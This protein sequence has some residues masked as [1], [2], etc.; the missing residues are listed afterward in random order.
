MSC[1]LRDRLLRI[2]RIDS[3]AADVRAL[4]SHAA[5]CP[6]CADVLAM[7]RALLPRLAA[8]PRPITAEERARLWAGIERESG[9]S[10]RE[11][12]DR[13]WFAAAAAAAALAALA[14]AVIPRSRPAPALTAGRAEILGASRA[15]ANGA[16]PEAEWLSFGARSRFAISDGAA[17]EVAEP[18]LVW[19]SPDEDDDAREIRLAEGALDAAVDAVDAG[20]ARTLV[21]TTPIARLEAVSARFHVE[22][23]RGHTSVE[24]SEGRV[25]IARARDEDPPV[26]RDWR[27]LAPGE[28]ATL[29]APAMP[30]LAAR[31]DG[32][33][34]EAPASS[35]PARA[36]PGA[37]QEHEPIARAPARSGGGDGPTAERPA[38]RARRGEP[39]HAS[40]APATPEI[41]PAGDRDR[42][43]VERARSMLGRDDRAATSLAEEVLERR[44]SH[45][46]EILALAVAAD[47]YRRRGMLGEADAY[48][49]RVIA[50][51]DGAGFREEALH[52]RAAIALE[53]GRATDALAFLAGAKAQ[54]PH[55]ALGP[56]RTALEAKALLA[57]GDRRAAASLLESAAKSAD[58]VLDRARLDVARALLA[59]DPGRARALIAPLMSRHNQFS[60]E[61][62]QIHRT[63]EAKLRARE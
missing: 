21:L 46:T 37:R 39:D 15:V 42:A 47:A 34:A 23:T 19:I 53:L 59:D 16:L 45:A 27:T 11:G 26:D 40:E 60:E 35:A 3:S 25:R 12:L 9:R 22:T 20:D 24:V 5:A 4:V 17:F 13:R 10:S 30:S 6:D 58:R 41:A 52:R 61:A 18:A 55:G 50:H 62:A 49:A 54:F 57:R 43:E 2:E 48:Y 56:E 7:L 1:T 38:E 8:P 63:A 28:R 33:G 36:R 32:G 31:T 29:G 14:V 44:P 51:P